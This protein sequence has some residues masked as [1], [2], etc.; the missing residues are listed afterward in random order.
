MAIDAIEIEIRLR[1]LLKIIHW[2]ECDITASFGEKMIANSDRQTIDSILYRNSCKELSRDDLI[3][4]NKIW[5]DYISTLT[6]SNVPLKIKRL[7]E[8]Q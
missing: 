3:T 6:G 4:A 2:V 8:V 1:K 5:Y 7:V